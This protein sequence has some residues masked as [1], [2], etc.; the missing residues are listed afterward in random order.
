VSPARIQLKLS[1]GKDKDAIEDARNCQMKYL[2]R[3]P[4]SES[5]QSLPK[6]AVPGMSAFPPIAT[7]LQASPSVRFVPQKD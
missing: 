3:S 5:G 6:S 2:R 1:D 4:M 7:K